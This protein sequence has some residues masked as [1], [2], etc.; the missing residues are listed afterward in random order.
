MKLFVPLFV[1]FFCSGVTFAQWSDDFSDG[2]FTNQPTWQGNDNHFIVENGWLRLN[3]PAAAGTSS[4]SVES[5]IANDASWEFVFKMSF[6]PSSSNY[7]KVYLI[8]DRESL[9]SPLNGY[10]LRLGYTDRD[11]C[12]FRQNGNITEKL[13]ASRANILNAS[14]NH[15]R[16]LITRDRQG[17]W[18]LKTDLTGG[19]DFTLEGG[20][21]DAQINQSA[22]FGVVC[23]YTAT[24]STGFY[25]S[26]F[27]VDGQPY[28]DTEPPTVTSCT[29][30]GKEVYI[31]F[32]R[33]C[34]CHFRAIQPLF[35][36]GRTLAPRRCPHGRTIIVFT[37]AC[38]RIDMRSTP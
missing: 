26:D 6:N 27:R 8:S 29:V 33:T 1:F 36:D 20:V 13:L 24:R 15:V 7:A 32:F 31:S 38:G 16:V 28:M 3:A 17:F 21:Q 18:T 2:D 37:P 14:S 4:L 30:E 25:F 10:F 23:T 34:G 11:I 9:N 22:Y 5:D 35:R 12:L 19:S